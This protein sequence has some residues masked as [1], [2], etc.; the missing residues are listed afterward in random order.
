MRIIAGRFKGTVIKTPKNA[1]IRPTTDRTREALFSS[2]GHEIEGAAF[3]DLFAGA[4]S[5]GMEALSRGAESVTF[6]D[7]HA[8][9]IKIIGE[10]IARLDLM[11]RA[12]L[13]K[14]D[15]RAALNMLIKEGARFGMAFLDPPYDSGLLREAL[16][17]EEL[18]GVIQGNGLII[19]EKRFRDL[20]TLEPPKGF[21]ST[22]AK[23]YGETGLEIFKKRAIMQ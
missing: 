12:R 6:V 2:L 16:I 10:L 4:G 19:V 15:W 1:S 20:D 11:S 5:V 14:M 3:L 23:R 13:I 9:A 22:Y 17:S 7:S 18:P 8:G 21:I